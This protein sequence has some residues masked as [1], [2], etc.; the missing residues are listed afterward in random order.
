M[1]FGPMKKTVLICLLCLTLAFAGALPCAALASQWDNDGVELTEV[2]K[3]P[4][5]FSGGMPPQKDAF[6]EGSG[7]WSYADP[8]ISVK[9]TSGRDNDCDWWMADIHIADASQ[10]RTMSAGGF[11]ASMVSPGTTLARRV[12]AILAIDGDY[13][14]QQAN[15][16]VLRQG[17]LFVNALDGTRDALLIDEDGDFHILMNAKAEEVGEEINGKKIINGLC[18]GPVLVKDGEL[19]EARGTKDMV[20]EKRRQRMALCQVGPLHYVAICCA[21]PARGSAGMDIQQFAEFVHSKGVTTAYNLDGGD[22]CMM[23]FN[24][25]KINDVRSRSTRDISDIVYFASSYINVD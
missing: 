13:Y 1:V 10:L 22:S 12:R 5:D 7:E 16:L 21:A 14:W 8:S 2:N 18:F 17:Q 4:I 6:V 9:I 20:P 23:I 25:T 15:G 11:D 19:M 3:L 24:G